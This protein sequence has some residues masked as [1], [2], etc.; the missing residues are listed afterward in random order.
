MRTSYV[1]VMHCDK[2][3]VTD[4]FRQR[5][6]IEFLVKEGNSV[7][8]ICERLR[9]VYGDVC[10]GASSVRR[11]V[12]HFKNENTDISDQPLCGQR[13]TAA[14]ELN[15]QKVDELIGQDRRV[16]V[17]EIAVM[18]DAQILLTSVFAHIPSFH[19]RINMLITFGTILVL[20]WCSKLCVRFYE[21]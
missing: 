10:M 14:T 18:K 17:R 3:A 11:W 4:M 21:G 13:R 8:F 16:T 15:K 20:Y 2:M 9:A 19:C 7:G 6:V 12:K 5:A 1:P